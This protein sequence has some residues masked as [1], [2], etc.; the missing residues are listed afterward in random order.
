MSTTDNGY[1]AP[2]HEGIRECGWDGAFAVPGVKDWGPVWECFQYLMREFDTRVEWLRPGWC[3]GYAFRPNA[4]NPN[5][6][7]RHSGAI[8]VDLNAPLHPNG[9]PTRNVFTSAQITTVNKILDEV[10]CSCHGWRVFRWG[11]DYTITPD[12]MHFEIDVA[13]TCVVSAA[14]SLKED[15]MEEQDFDRIKALFREAL[16]PVKEANV[17]QTQRI[18]E[19]ERESAKADLRQA[20]MIKLLV[21]DMKAENA[22]EL[23]AEADALEEQGNRRLQLVVE[24]ET[25]PEHQDH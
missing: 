11:G 4:N 12:A 16:Q 7:S 1:S 13:P 20:K 10:K 21:K 9:V 3:W 14:Q 23:E 24:M 17:R 18:M 2:P 6:L 8:A 25:Q 19:M 15:K 22:A 5:A